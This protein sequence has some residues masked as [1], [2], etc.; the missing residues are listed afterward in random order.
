MNPILA[1]A[2]QIISFLVSNRD[3]IKQ[4]VLQI[5]QM[6]GSLP[7]NQKAQAVKTAIGAAMGVE[8]QIEQAWPIVSPVF[9]LAV[10]AIKG[11]ATPQTNAAS[12]TA[13]AV[14]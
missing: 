9:N 12:A 1:T 8:A 6:A 13:P 5:E 2:L 14:Q 10:A 3:A 4:L 7:G 11:A